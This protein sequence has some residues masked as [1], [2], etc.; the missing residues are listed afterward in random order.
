MSKVIKEKITILMSVIIIAL[1]L[2]I[3]E[4]STVVIPAPL[5]SI[6][7]PTLIITLILATI[8]LSF[9]SSLFLYIRPKIKLKKSSVI[10]LVLLG[11]LIAYSLVNIIITPLSES[12][13]IVLNGVSHDLL[14][15][16]SNT[17]KVLSGV[18]LLVNIVLIV[19]IVVV[20][21]NNQYF[22]HL[23]H[24]IFIALILL[25]FT[26][27]VYSLIVEFPLYVEVFVSDFNP[28]DDIVSFF[29]NRNPFASFLL[30]GL[31]SLLYFN[32]TSEKK[33]EKTLCIL[34]M[35]PLF[36]AIT[37]TFSKTN[38]LLSYLLVF[39]LLI[40]HYVQIFSKD[41]KLFIAESLVIGIVIIFGILLLFTPL[42]D[43]VSLLFRI[44]SFINNKLFFNSEGTFE[45]RFMK[46]RYAYAIITS[47][48]RIFYMGSS[49]YIARFIYAVNANF[50]ITGDDYFYGDYHNGFVEV[51]HTFGLVGLLLYI[52]IIVYVFYQ[53]IRHF[54]K[55]KALSYFVLVN[56]LFFIL[57]SQ[58][59]SF[60]ALLFKTEGIVASS[61][62]VL[63]LLVLLNKDKNSQ[64]TI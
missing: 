63:P 28:T 1:A 4:Q 40:V 49:P 12:V 18:T 44:K 35:I 53:V 59:E 64:K 16:I 45:T 58:T 43:T 23:V 19:I 15:N 13:T 29:G 52:A 55:D 25:A 50:N 7:P 8:M 60:A 6:K 38:M 11:L 61:V 42:F 24:F 21:P 14:F 32:L 27:L 30:T 62:F 5:Y 51:F 33:R 46:W 36:I 17:Q 3:L 47:S 37:F 39:V 10:F 20:L 22:K 9:A 56:L 57:R 41:K 54:K 2:F 48:N 34:L 31:L 26:S